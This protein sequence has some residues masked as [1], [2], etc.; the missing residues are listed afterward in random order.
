MQTLE[1][2]GRVIVRRHAQRPCS[3]GPES[4]YH[5]APLPA[6]SPRQSRPRTHP[7]GYLGE[8]LPARHGEARGAKATSGPGA[9][10]RRVRFW[11]CGQRRRCCCWAPRS[12]RWRGRPRRP[13][14]RHVRTSHRRGRRRASSPRRRPTFPRYVRGLFCCRFCA[15]P[16]LAPAQT[17]A[18]IVGLRLHNPWCM[19]TRDRSA[20]PW[21]RGANPEIRV[22]C[23]GVPR[24]PPF[25]LRSPQPCAPP[26]SARCPP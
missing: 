21:G 25:C 9:R 20:T 18:P 2:E 3:T 5:A 8:A 4:T 22:R 19:Q 6:P 23:Q 26:G 17:P 13:I 11:V 7:R 16:A 15:D 10:G 12:A 14:S 24:R 1:G